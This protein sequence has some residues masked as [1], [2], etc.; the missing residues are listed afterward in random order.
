MN[1][2]EAD[3][4]AA[5]L[6]EAEDTRA[7]VIDAGFTPLWL[8]VLAAA[9]CGPAF[10]MLLY[11]DSPLM[12]I[13]LLLVAVMAIT[14]TIFARRRGRLAPKRILDQRSVGANAL[15]YLPIGL[16]LPAM[17]LLSMAVGP[18]PPTWLVVL[19]AV[20]GAGAVLLYQRLV[21]RYQR[22]RLKER[23]YGR[24]DLV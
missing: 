2:S 22:R 13:G 1:P 5:A 23:D 12:L 21:T 4:A 6:R 24:F 19:V 18:Q 15:F 14:T 11:R 10:A 17:S 8:D 20:V 16:L 9:L 7:E 3:E